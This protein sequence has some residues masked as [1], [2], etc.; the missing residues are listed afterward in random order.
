MLMEYLTS[1]YSG[2]NDPSLCCGGGNLL[3]DTTFLFLLRIQQLLFNS[4]NE[5]HRLNDSSLNI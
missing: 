4:A 1:F 3:P 5:E 2:G